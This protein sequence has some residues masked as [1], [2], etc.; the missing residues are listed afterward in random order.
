MR[1]LKR[2]VPV[3]PIALLAMAWVTVGCGDKSGAEAGATD[4][5][6]SIYEASP[7][8]P[9]FEPSAVPLSW[10]FHD[11]GNPAA[12]DPVGDALEAGEFPI[13]RGGTDS[14]AQVWWD[15]LEVAEDGVMASPGGGTLRYAAGYA[16]VELDRYY[17][18]RADSVSRVHMRGLRQPGDV[19]GS[20]RI[21]L[22]ARAVRGELE[23]L[24]EIYQP[25]SAPRI[26]AFETTHECVFNTADMIVPSLLEGDLGERYLGV[27]LLN[28]KAESITGLRARVLD[29]EQFEETVVQFPA[30]GAQA[31]TQLSFLLK[32]KRAPVVSEAPVVVT[33]QVDSPSL[34]WS[35]ALEVELGV[36]TPQANHRQTFR[37]A[38]DLSTQYYGVVPPSEEA[39]QSG[40]GVVLSLHGA[41]VEAMN[42]ANSYRAKPWGYIIAPTNRRPF[43]FDWQSWGRLDALESLADA[44]LRYGIDPTRVY[45]T[46]HSMGGHG[47][48]H[49]GVH[50]PGLFAVLGPSA[51]WS[52]FMSYGGLQESSGA[53]GRAS[54]HHDTM[55]YLSNLSR[56]AVYVVHGD[57]DN[58]V[59][60]S[61]GRALYEAVQAYTDD[62]AM[63]EQPGAGHW[64]D[65]PESDGVDCVDWPPL[66]S[67]MEER[68]LDPI[69]LEFSYRSP[70]PSL[71][72]L[73]SFVTLE[74]ALDPFDDLTIESRLDGQA[75]SVE[76][77]NVASL[78]IDGSALLSRDVTSLVVNGETQPL[79]E[80]SLH[81]GQMV[82]KNP[83]QYGP[84][85]QVLEKPFLFAF[86]Q[87]SDGVFES[88]AAYLI[89]TWSV[90]GNGHAGAIPLA[91]LTEEMKAERN[92]IYVG[93]SSSEIDEAIP[94][95]FEWSADSVAIRGVNQSGAIVFVHPSK[96]GG[97]YGVIHATSGRERILFRYQPFASR[98]N[99]PDYFTF[100]ASEN[101]SG[102]FDYNWNLNEDN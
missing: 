44:K 89:S 28:L 7:I 83:S 48:W 53:W 34:D 95:A 71:N 86:A 79:E 90:I 30:L 37:S 62:V 43:G 60:I 58:N 77:N 2:S 5:G 78:R 100:G 42:Q 25:R 26:Q 47:T 93:V 6:Q 32:P 59:P 76:T 8:A 52:S 23:V 9:A 19:Y 88:Y 24:G 75:L 38:M 74:A 63:H 72:A 73:H 65:G 22:P 3:L 67:L 55:D 11:V 94:E 51:G 1:F 81:F 15:P 84:F 18:L 66:F 87:D 29:S 33:L 12:S 16:I 36:T 61:E 56:R 50:H 41:S 57:A 10:V 101:R 39:T 82:Q 64:W 99:A 85:N 14:A 98:F 35:Y 49:L 21:R 13:P 54:A 96:A 17:F 27:A 97:L 91:E 68:R 80:G 4:S 31:V 102:F 70:T 45:L 69:E 92:I 46:G 20:G 40:H